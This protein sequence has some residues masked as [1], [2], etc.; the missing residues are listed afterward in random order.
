MTLDKFLYTCDLDTPTDFEKAMDALD[1]QGFIS[2]RAF[3]E[4]AKER[5][6]ERIRAQLAKDCD[7]CYGTG[8]FKGFGGPCS[9]GCPTK[10]GK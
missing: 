7:V 6:E 8:R 5:F 1:R 10:G 2:H 9:E 4:K 3:P